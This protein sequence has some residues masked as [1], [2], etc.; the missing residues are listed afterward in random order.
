MSLFGLVQKVGE[1][2]VFGFSLMVLDFGDIFVMII[3]Q[4]EGIGSIFFFIFFNL[5]FFYVYIFENKILVG[6]IVC[7]ILE[8]LV[9]VIV[10]VVVLDVGVQY[11]M[12][13]QENFKFG[14]FLCNVGLCMLF[15]GEGLS[16]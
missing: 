1:N 5:G 11:V 4:L 16:Q 15:G 12:G 10:S 6:V 9:D 8:V 3:L 14:I 7:V 13:F 2:G